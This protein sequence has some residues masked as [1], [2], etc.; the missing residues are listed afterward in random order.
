M[1]EK[2][3]NEN[4]IYFVYCFLDTRKP[5]NYVFE[6][7]IFDYEPIYIGKGKG[8]R[9]ERH[10]ILYKKY[11]NRFYSKLKSIINDNYEPKFIIIEN[12]LSEDESFKKEIH[13]INLI[14]RIENGG[15]LTNLSDGGE[16]QSGYK[17]TEEVKQKMSESRKGDKNSMFNKKHSD[18]TKQKI[19]LAN[20]CK[21]NKN[22]GK[23][24]I[25]IHGEDKANEIIK[26]QKN[27]INDRSGD[28]NGMF[29]KK[30]KEESIQKMKDNTIKLFGENN[31]NF[32][33]VYKES[34]KTFDDWEL[35]NINGDILIIS[36]LNKF[37]RENNLNDSS[38]RSLYYG[39]RKNHR[40]WIKVV[41]LTNN[42]KNKKPLN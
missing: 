37:C 8:K 34:E 1:N 16:G 39:T 31:P 18:E 36:N 15:P 17:F 13:F 24:L 30:H 4:N 26:K 40:G 3:T 2:S 28:N 35:T 25:E 22:K 27:S 38:M 5:G 14:G 42:V 33:R 9:P 19:S 6:D 29:G 12:N 32:G 41:K 7:I 21:P 23:K 11:N 20:K 10:L